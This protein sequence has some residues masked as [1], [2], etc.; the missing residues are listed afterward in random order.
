M[1]PSLELDAMLFFEKNPGA[2][3][4]YQALYQAMLERFAQ[5]TVRV[6]KTQ[7]SFYNPRM[8]AAVSI[9]PMAR[10]KAAVPCIT[11]SFGLGFRLNSPRIWQAA[12]P[13]PGRWTHHV[14]VT[15]AQQIDGALLD[16][17]DQA[18]AFSLSK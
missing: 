18:Y 10:K 15:Q 5:V 6:Q 17:L 8:F 7:I 11:V 14:L 12:E 13:Y 9:P 4:L 1:E 16:W 2:F 3:S